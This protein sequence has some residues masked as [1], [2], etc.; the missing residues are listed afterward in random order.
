MSNQPFQISCEFFLFC[1]SDG[2]TRREY[3][4]HLSSATWRRRRCWR[5]TSMSARSASSSSATS[6]R[7]LRSSRRRRRWVS[8]YPSW[9]LRRPEQPWLTGFLLHDLSLPWLQL[10]DGAPRD[11]RLTTTTLRAAGSASVRSAASGW[12]QATPDRGGQEAEGEREAEG[13][14]GA[15]V[16]ADDSVEMDQMTLDRF[17]VRQ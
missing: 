8:P 3:P 15:V 9:R 6:S 5:R 2:T 4:E 13:D 16:V 11:A 17:V 10:L 14:V 1:F 12:D 7:T